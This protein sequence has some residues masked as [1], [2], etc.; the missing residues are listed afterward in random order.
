MPTQLQGAEVKRS[1]KGKAVLRST[2]SSLPWRPA[3]AEVREEDPRHVREPVEQLGM[4]R[5]N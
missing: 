5:L 2:S 1:Y 4:L 3:F